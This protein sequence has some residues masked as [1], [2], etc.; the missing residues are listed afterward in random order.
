MPEP[1][2][3]AGY[4]LTVKCIA[5]SAFTTRISITTAYSMIGS[6]SVLSQDEILSFLERTIKS[7]KDGNLKPM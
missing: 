5:E 2:I 1:E 4:E 7:I 3:F 6:K